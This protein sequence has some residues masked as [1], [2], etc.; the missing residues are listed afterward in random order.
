[1]QALRGDLTVGLLAQA[2]RGELIVDRGRKR[3]AAS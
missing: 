3:Y 1:M 2:P